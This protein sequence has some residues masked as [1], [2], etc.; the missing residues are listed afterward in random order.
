RLLT[1]PLDWPSTGHP[2]RAG[3]SSF[4]LS[5]TN[6]HTIL[7]QAPQEPA[8]DA[9]DAAPVRPA[10]PAPVPL[11]LSGRTEE[12]LRA[13][14]GRL[15]SHLADHPGLPLTDLAFSLATSRSA[16]E[17]RAAV[18]TDDPDALTRALTA[19]RDA[20][21]DGALLTGS[22]DR[23]RLAFLFTGQG[24]Q[25]PGMGRELYDTHPVYAQ[26][27]D[28]VL[29]RFDLELDRPLRD[30]LFA[31]PGTPEAELLDDTGYTQP[32]L[33]ALEVAL[34]RL[35]ESWGLRPDYVAGHSIGEF[36][37]AHAA[38]VLSLEDACTLV[39]ARGRLMAALPPGGAMA[40]VEATE[41]EVAAVLT[42]YEGRAAIAAVNTPGSLTVSGDEDAVLAV[43]A[44][45]KELGRRTK[46]LRVSHAF[47][48]PHMDPMLADFA[49][50]VGSVTCHAPTVPLVSTVTGALLT[51]EELAAP[52]YWTGQ[53]RGTVRFAD[54]VRHLT[55][56]GVTTFFE[57]GPDAVLS[58]AVR[59]GTGE[60]D[61]ATAVPALRRDRPEAPALTTALAR[62]HLHGVR[63]DWEAVFAGSGA[64]RIDLPTY[65]F[66]RERFWP[67]PTAGTAAPAQ[68]AD[69]ADAEFWSAVER[70]DLASLGSSLDLDDDTLTAVVPALSSWR[71]K[72]RER[73]T[74]DGW[75]YR[76]TWKALTGPA[77]GGRPS[78]TWLVLVPAAGAGEWAE[79]VIGA[80]GTDAVRIDIAAPQ[81]QEL[82]QRMRELSA[83][84]GGFAGVLALPATAGEG[85][86]D[87]AT[88]GLLLTATAVQALGDAGID[89]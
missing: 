23:G 7:E 11:V 76:T 2:R 1:E 46:R 83:E 59:E 57:L 30:I 29:A 19:L 35:A 87:P 73:S 24:S 69:E 53:V 20:D 28:A 5:G 54:A 61:R 14:A 60:Q 74:V 33:F 51:H 71:R 68:P 88:E 79:A 45:F 31:E 16:L 75:R 86:A 70:A 64:R 67:E 47:H 3:V 44:H 40:S 52:E 9:T 22:P 48:S 32:A 81:R 8:E 80:L 66:Q 12:G 21:A 4:G 36:A 84:H 39:A 38:G 58:G 63:V 85:D 34:F 27:L 82:A 10:E 62:L 43:A 25:R 26:A 17:H 55:E 18:V 65:P 37:A 41:D 6:V 77:A 42:A 78:G 89:A 49:R 56:H 72:S 15:L 50:A 13:Q